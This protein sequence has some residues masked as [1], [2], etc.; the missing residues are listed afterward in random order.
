MTSV[1]ILT[2][3]KRQCQFIGYGA[4]PEFIEP[5]QG[6][7]HLNESLKYGKWMKHLCKNMCLFLF[8]MILCWPPWSGNKTVVFLEQSACVGDSA[9]NCCHRPAA[10]FNSSKHPP[11]HHGTMVSLFSKLLYAISKASLYS[12][13]NLQI[14]PRDNQK[15]N[16]IWKS[17]LVLCLP[18]ALI[19]MSQ[20]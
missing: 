8:R 11:L 3:A 18:N 19:L 6:A 5:N 14:C 1:R 7:K 20:I 12:M 4:L 9:L 10:L 2:L 13:Y 17:D 15:Y 16:L